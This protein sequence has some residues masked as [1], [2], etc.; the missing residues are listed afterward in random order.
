MTSASC[1]LTPIDVDR[2]TAHPVVH[3]QP[4]MESRRTTP[5]VYVENAMETDEENSD[6]DLSTDQNNQVSAGYGGA[7]SLS[8]SGWKVLPSKH[9]RHTVTTREGA[10]ASTLSTLSFPIR[11]HSPLV[12]GLSV[13]LYGRRYKVRDGYLVRASLWSFFCSWCE[14][15]A[16]QSCGRLW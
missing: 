5:T 14:S 1:L 7:G 13:L 15:S 4:A 3:V 6:N 9:E 2:W 16:S 11:C 10:V 12:K 8:I